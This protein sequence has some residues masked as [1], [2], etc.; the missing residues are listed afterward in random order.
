[1]R[2]NPDD[3]KVQHKSTKSNTNNCKLNSHILKYKEKYA[4]FIIKKGVSMEQE[5]NKKGVNLLLIF[6][7]VI[8]AV[9]CVLFATGTISLKSNE[10]T[11][12]SDN[13]T[14]E[15]TNTEDN[16]ANL[17][18]GNI[19]VTQNGKVISNEIPSD[20]VGKYTN[21]N[22]SESYIQLTNGNVEV[23]E[24]TGGGP[25]KVFKNDEVKL[26]INY[27]NTNYNSE[28]YVTVEF[29]IEK[30]NEGIRRTYTY[31]GEKSSHDNAYHFKTPDPTPAGG[32]GQND[33]PYSK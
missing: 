26:Y 10:V 33:Y 32:E 28:Q 19:I 22:S 21:K 20:L 15:N 7:I 23:S 9:L 6:I 5:K 31:I 3:K 18:N 1:M 11:D 14:N 2:Y 12:G 27:L 13:Q 30:D 29:F 24:P 16:S 17:L 4:I 25:A 8:L